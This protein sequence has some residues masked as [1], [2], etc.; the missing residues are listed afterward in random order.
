MKPI[1]KMRHDKKRQMM[2]SHGII[3]TY[4]KNCER[5]KKCIPK[6]EM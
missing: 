3:I 5:I 2:H 6:E 4:D 1:S